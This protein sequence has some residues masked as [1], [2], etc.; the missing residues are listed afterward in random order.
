MPKRRKNFPDIHI[1]LAGAGPYAPDP[2]LQLP[3]I[4]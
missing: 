3:K 2:F 1:L 4:A